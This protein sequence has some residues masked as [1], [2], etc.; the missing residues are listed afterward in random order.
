MCR[1]DFVHTY[2][3]ALGL[4]LAKEISIREKRGLLGSEKD[5]T[6]EVP[7]FAMLSLPP[8]A[9]KLSDEQGWTVNA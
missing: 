2:L 7:A 9:T 8:T 3:N 6:R 4:Q 1:I 5:V